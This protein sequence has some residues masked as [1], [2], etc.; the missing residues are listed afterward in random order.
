MILDIRQMFQV[1]IR[2]W[3][4]FILITTTF[5]F[6]SAV[7]SYYVVPPLYEAKSDILVTSNDIGKVNDV[8]PGDIDS[9]LKLIQT[10]RVIIKSPIIL[11]PVIENLNLDID[12][13]A[14][15][16]QIKIESAENSQVFSI[17]VRNRS[18]EQ[19]VSLVNEVSTVFQKEVQR[20]ME[21]NNIHILT[22]AKFNNQVKPVQP[23]PVLY[24]TVSFFLGMFFS[25]GVVFLREVLDTTLKSEEKVRNIFHVPVLGT[26]PSIQMKH[27]NVTQDPGISTFSTLD[28]KNKLLNTYNKGLY[29]SYYQ[30]ICASLK[31]IPTFKNKQLLLV[32]SP[33]PSEGKSLTSANLAISLA[34]SGKKTVYVD[35]DLRKPSGHYLFQLS[36]QRGVTSYLDGDMLLNDIIQ[37]S[38]TRNLSVISA[39]PVPPNPLDLLNSEQLQTFFHEL[40][41]RFTMIIIDSPP[42]FVA[43]TIYT[44]A[45]ADGCI[46][47]INAKSTK[48]Q[49]VRTSLDKFEEIEANL[50]GVVLNNK[51][52]KNN[53][54][55]SY[56]Y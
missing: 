29:D 50:L 18:Q 56:Y 5:V 11:E 6:T 44:V 22:P 49:A 16:K 53:Q 9:N 4:V 30:N 40:K 42:L 2:N 24:M 47:V 23:K 46:L 14:M 25:I 7:I 21:L 10:Y 41:E 17:I 13:D 39:G 27:R 52:M 34:Q 8:S 20:L 37:P 51:K 36:N 19:A 55:S 28:Y 1:I 33:N 12:V 26:V 54:E 31:F 43:D 32:T 15:L 48:L 35:M 3:W 45:L 38:P